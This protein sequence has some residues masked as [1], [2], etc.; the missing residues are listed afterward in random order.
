MV[1]APNVIMAGHPNLARKLRATGR[2]PAVVDVA[3]ATALRELSQSGR[4]GS[5]A[6]FMFGPDFDEDLPDAGVAVLANGLAASGFTVLVHSVFTARG[7]VFD[8]RVV[9]D[10]GPLTMAELLTILTRPGDQPSPRHEPPS[11]PPPPR[12]DLLIEPPP[13][14]WAASAPM[15]APPV[16]A[17]PV[18]AP[19]VPVPPVP[20]PPAPAPPVPAPPR[21]QAAPAE[22]PP[23][24]PQAAPA[25]EPPP[26]PAPDPD[27]LPEEGHQDISTLP[28]DA[29]D[30][31]ES[32]E[33]EGR[34]EH[35]D[36]HQGVAA[37]PAEE[38][39]LAESMWKETAPELD[40]YSDL[41][42][43]PQWQ[44]DL[45]PVQGVA[46]APSRR[47]GGVVLVA[48]AAGLVLLAG[49]AAVAVLTVGS[50]KGERR[51][52]AASTSARPS[53]KSP[54]P[55]SPVPAS[56]VPTSSPTA[57]RPAEQYRPTGVQIVDSRVSIEVRWKDG[58][59]GKAA[60]YVVGGPAGQT[61]STLASSPPGATKV[62]VAALNP[63]V[64][65][66]LTVVAV[67]DVDRVAYAKPVCTHRGKREG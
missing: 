27:D 8:P 67:V 15:P 53:P 33:W 61:P 6:T 14:P 4:I 20:A 57:V 35:Q 25:E 39:D 51:P 21:P 60:Y 26:R 16:P 64:E 49:L 46:P 2:F 59:R 50:G 28:A 29:Q 12:H 37:A 47:R 1:T 3:A 54:P 42:P 40:H 32:P 18:P 44:G 63:S 13:G 10:M 34:P 11:E 66:C 17:P 38:Q 52:E 43:E 23:P 62:V 58:S 45:V 31:A 30:P 7:D 5:P 56:A 55:T 9:A 22:E 41:L 19:P 24:R 48:A 36:D 65:Y